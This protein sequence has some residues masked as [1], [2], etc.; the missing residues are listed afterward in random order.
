[1]AIPIYI[2]IIKLAII[3]SVDIAFL[4]SKNIQK[5]Q[6]NLP[7]LHLTMDCTM[8]ILAL[9]AFTDNYIWLLVDNTTRM[10]DCID[11]GDAKPVIEWAAANRFNLR[12]ILLTHHHADHIGG[13]SK[14]LE[15]FPDRTVYGPKDNRIPHITLFAQIGDSISLSDYHF[16]VLATPGHTS[17][18]ISYY[19]PEHSLLFCGDTLFSAGCGRVFDGTMEE[20]HQSLQLFKELP[21]QTKVFCAHEYTL[22]NLRFAQSVEPENQEIQH[23]LAK[24]L[25]KPGQCTLPSTITLERLTNPFLRTNIK[26]VQEYASNHGAEDTSSLSV[27]RTLREQKNRF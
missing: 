2:T 9:P 7:H 17:S 4:K 22:Q 15:H 14:L 19:E 3:S 10:F 16:H 1:M 6:Q 18:H 23:Y 27:F 12:S 24:C 5:C 13:T 8:N 26:A 25:H 11:P 21:P 20:L